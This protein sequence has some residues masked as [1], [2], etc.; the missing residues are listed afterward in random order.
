MTQNIVYEKLM[1]FGLF[2]ERISNI[3]SSEDFANRVNEINVRDFSNKHFS[4][5]K[6][7][8]TRNN[9]VPRLLSIPHPIPY[10]E[11]CLIIKENWDTIY[12]KIGEYDD[13]TDRK[14]ISMIVPEP[15]NLNR[16]VT[17][18]NYDRKQDEKFLVLEK[19]LQAKYFVH[20]DIAN[21]YASIYSHSI[22]WA[23]VT[24]VVAKDNIRTHDIWY[25]VLDKKIRYL[26]KNETIG[27]PIGPDTSV[28]IS[29]I[30][31]AEIDRNLS[32]YSYFRYIDDYKCYCKDRAEAENFIQ[33][34]NTQLEYFNLRLNQVKTQ[35][36]E[37]PK[38]YEN[39]WI[40][41]IKSY[42]KIFLKED[43]L[44]NKHI[45]DLSLFFDLI[46]KLVKKEPSE[47]SI[48]YAVKILA[49]KKFKEKDVFIFTVLSLSRIC[50]FYPYF[51]DVFEDLFDNNLSF[52]TENNE[53]IATELENLL[54]EHLRHNRSD[55]ALIGIY[56]FCKYNLLFKDFEGYSNS[57]I[58]QRDCLP[59]LLCYFYAK[60]NNLNIDKYISLV[61]KLKEEYLEDEWW[62]YIY[63]VFKN[64]STNSFFEDIKYKNVYSQMKEKEIN[65]IT[66]TFN[67]IIFS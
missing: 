4:Y 27:I 17:M 65:F 2:P 58:E 18:I 24:K 53:G 57:L 51:I 64:E 52:F 31:L 67:S 54:K 43:E 32:H 55:I 44:S 37:L 20:A 11:L 45:N 39:E 29:E 59:A 22:P 56:I 62:V 3:F 28:I 34:L 7:K 36:I 5:I 60:Q 49:T 48:K 6:F 33:D 42:I 63:Q 23:L 66:E 10:R 38:V 16:L 14:N 46:I 50:F 9:N 40:H 41:E 35:I 8:Q 26:Q 30:I 12:S 13:N 25:N 15:N 1:K 47:S 21:C 19:S 61:V